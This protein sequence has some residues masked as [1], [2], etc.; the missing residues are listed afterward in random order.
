MPQTK[1][2]A[3]GDRPRQRIPVPM[4]DGGFHAGKLQLEGNSWDPT[5]L[6]VNLVNQFCP[7]IWSQ[8]LRTSPTEE[9]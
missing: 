1:N 5:V 9:P 8:L 2:K 6:L 7:G 3:P 4:W